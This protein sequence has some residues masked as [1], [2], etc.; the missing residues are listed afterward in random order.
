MKCRKLARECVYVCMCV[1]MHLAE[2]QKLASDM[3]EAGNRCVFIY[4][5]VYVCILRLHSAQ[6]HKLAND[7]Q[8]AGK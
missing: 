5:L 3:L 4:I 1:C 6:L 2:L 8:E 7:I